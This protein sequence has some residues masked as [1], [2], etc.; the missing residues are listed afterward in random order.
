MLSRFRPIP[1]RYALMDRRTDGR[2]ERE[3]RFLTARQHKNRPFSAIRGKNRS[4]TD[5]RTDFLYQY[6]ASVCWRA[7]KT[8]LNSTELDRTVQFSWDKFSFPLCIELTTSCDDRRRPL[9]VVAA[10]RRFSSNDRHCVD[11]PIHESVRWLW[12]TCDERQLRRRI[13]VNRRKS[14]PVQC[15]TAGNWTELNSSVEFIFPL[16]IASMFVLWLV[17]CEFV[18]SSRVYLIICIL[19]VFWVWLSVP[20]LTWKDSS[21]TW[22]IMC[23]VE[24]DVINSAHLRSR[25][26]FSIL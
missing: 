11:W 8:E 20:V 24:W 4:K 1:E 26:L 22:A 21:T 10:R 23:R 9:P 12:R 17:C 14:S 19:L 15:T 2:R 16:C 3:C 5:G 13:V 18:V 25:Q 7:I 6:R